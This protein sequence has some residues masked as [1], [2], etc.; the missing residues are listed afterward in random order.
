MIGV[1]GQGRAEHDQRRAIARAGDGLLQRQSAHRLHGDGDGLHDLA[2]LIQRAGH[3]PS[4]GCD[5][6]ALVVADVVDD[7]IAAE[8][9][10][11]LG[12]GD[13]VRAHHIV[14]HDLDAEIA[15]GLHHALDGLLMRAGHHHHVGRARFGHHFRFQ[16]TA[17]HRLQISYDG[18]AGK[19]LAQAAHAMQAL[20]EN[21][22]RAGFQ[23]IHARPQGHFRRGERFVDVGEVEG[24]LDDGGHGGEI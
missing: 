22:R 5:A 17:V 8:I 4:G 2:Q 21:E 9:L 23:P 24:Y 20:R 13:H 15:S 11:P 6:A 19:A 1:D 10:Q 16:V 3:A 12:P 18:H 14:A 7:V